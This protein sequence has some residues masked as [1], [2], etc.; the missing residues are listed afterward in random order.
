MVEEEIVRLEGQIKHLQKDVTIEQE[1][2]K[3]ESKAKHS[4]NNQRYS[5]NNNND[6]NNNNRVLQAARANDH[7][8]RSGY[9]TKALHF[10]SKAINGGYSLTDFTINCKH[11]NR[12]TG[13]LSPYAQVSK[14]SGVQE[15]QIK[16]SR[17]LKST[18]S[19]LRDF[20][21]PTPKVISY[22]TR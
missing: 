12:T 14:E 22:F 17:M 5:V 18:L 3:L 11:G 19:P 6:N 2:T 4:Q 13:S 21:H 7:P 20:R 8:Q 1:A 15:T 10:I 16:R 9:E